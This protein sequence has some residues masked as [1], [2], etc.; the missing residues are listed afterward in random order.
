MTRDTGGASSGNCSADEPQIER[1]LPR[2][3]NDLGDVL[4]GGHLDPPTAKSLV[5]PAG[6]NAR[7]TVPG[8]QFDP[9]DMR[10]IGPEVRAYFAELHW[11][12][13]T[14]VKMSDVMRDRT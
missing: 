9:A 6:D 5:I 10:T 13:V 4:A 1:L 11:T 14:A 12:A 7:S 3:T 8:G 2:I